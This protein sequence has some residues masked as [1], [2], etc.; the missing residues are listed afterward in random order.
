MIRVDGSDSELHTNGKRLRAP[1]GRALLARTH[2]REDAQAKE[3]QA[4]STYGCH[5]VPVG[6]GPAADPPVAHAPYA[7][8]GMIWESGGDE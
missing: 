5:T 8:I 3:V 7:A 4:K 1:E 6:P 2:D